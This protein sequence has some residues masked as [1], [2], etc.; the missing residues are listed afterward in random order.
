M[1]KD[2]EKLLESS[3]M[4]E[5]VIDYI[6]S[7]ENALDL[8]DDFISQIDYHYSQQGNYICEI[9]PFRGT[10]CSKPKCE[11]EGAWKEWALNKSKG[12]G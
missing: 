7:L 12:G 6:Y 1:K 3:F 11:N 8:L 9:C 10:N 2:M 5:E 4:G